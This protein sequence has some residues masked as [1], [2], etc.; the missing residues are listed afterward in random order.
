MTRAD[1]AEQLLK[2][3]DPAAA[4]ARLQEQVRDKPGDPGLRIFL[5]QLLCVLGQWDRALNQLKVAT[6]LDPIAIPMAQTYSAAL[7]CE[8]V[9]ARVFAG[10][11]SPMIFGQPDSWLALLIEALLVG[12][13]GE[14]SQALDLRARA[15][16][17]APASSGD[18][19][20]TAF[21]WICDADSRLGPVIEAIINGRYYWVPYARLLKIQIEP[22]E[23]LRDLVWMPAMLQFENGGQS[24]ALLPTRYVG[25]E[26]S[27]DTGIVLAR[28]TVWEEIA[29]DTFRGLGQ[30]V[31]A[32]DVDER[33]LLEIRDITLATAA[34]ETEAA[35]DDHA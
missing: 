4:L 14:A 19:D 6:E 10:E 8:N 15:L 25:S 24:V 16:E 11:T 17:E 28:K 9:R 20:G 33:S 1:A 5:F 3:G 21:S 13:R 2:E 23:D 26:Q 7:G 29:T 12:A 18:V 30:R 35:S 34:D 31:L 22:P 27:P 32:T